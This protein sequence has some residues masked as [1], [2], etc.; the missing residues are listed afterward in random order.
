[1]S[2]ITHVWNNQEI[3]FAG[4]GLTLSG[5]EIPQG[6][7][8]A[9][10]MCKANGREWF[11]FARSDR[12]TNFLKVFT[13]SPQ[14]CGEVPLILITDG[15]NENRG[16]WVHRRIAINLAQWI[17]PEF[18]F[19]VSGK[20]EELLATGQTTITDEDVQSEVIPIELPVTEELAAMRLLLEAKKRKEWRMVNRLEQLLS[21][22]ITQEY[23]N[24]TAVRSN[25]F[26]QLSQAELNGCSAVLKTFELTFDPADY[27]ITVDVLKIF[28]FHG[29]QSPIVS[30][31]YF[32]RVFQ[33][34]LK[35]QSLEDYDRYMSVKRHQTNANGKSKQ[36]Y[37][38][39]K[40]EKVPVIWGL[41]YRS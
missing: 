23:V 39:N 40:Q 14:Y 13:T 1:M 28:S 36:A 19:W 35:L 11:T 30:A 26:N 22:P 29:C 32:H 31:K 6:F 16:T 25:C 10:A 12:F 27:V 20:I 9:T 33:S 34:F 8:N 2:V 18:D 37:I 15:L 17:S 7:V 38:S 24:E 21:M 41:R 3:S 4:E 5:R